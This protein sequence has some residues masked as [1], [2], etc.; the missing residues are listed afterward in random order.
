M[1]Q[2]ETTPRRSDIFPDEDYATDGP[3]CLIWAVVGLFSAVIA[4][5]IVLTA[6]WAGFNEGVDRARAT[7][8]AVT[9][10]NITRQCEF[11]PQD[12]AAGRVSIVQG[13]FDALQRAGGLPACALPYIAGATQMYLESIA[14]P[15]AVPATAT[16]QPSATA[17]L[18]P[19]ATAITDVQPTRAPTDNT[20]DGYD[21]DALFAEAQTYQSSG[22]YEEAIR[23][24]DA[25][26]AL[27]PDYQRQAVNQ[28]LFN[29]LTQLATI[30]YRTA[31]GSL[32]EAI[33]LTNRAREYGDVGDLN[34]E[35]VVAQTYLEAQA[36]IG[37]DYVQAI[38][39]LNQV[40]SYAP[41]YRDANQI[42][43]DQ[44]VG[45]GDALMFGEPCRAVSQYDAALG[46]FQRPATQTKRNDAQ[47][48]C[49]G[50]AA[51]TSDPAATPADSAPPT[52]APIGQPGT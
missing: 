50:I 26:I 44:L 30:N 8:A 17:T 3:G 43:F 42:L 48:A 29:A 23:T 37:V 12:I 14:T 27:N 11:L 45:Y 7:Q 33:F 38:R 46:L 49:Q 18:I 22:E 5:A 13:R 19:P 41:N 52:I 28:A 10:E 20:S 25:I 24:L 2:D 6:T 1:H 16:P 31:D 47:Q 51:P 35:A 32:S 9:Q 4:V 15:T 36:Y 21:L 40:R 39:L 34:F